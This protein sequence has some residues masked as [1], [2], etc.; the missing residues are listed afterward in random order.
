MLII[1]LPAKTAAVFFVDNSAKIA[2]I[3]NI[4]Q[5]DDILDR[6]S[7]ANATNST[8]KENDPENASIEKLKFEVGQ[9]MGIKPKAKNKKN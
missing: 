6:K 1:I 5:G 7:D 3:I 8:N 9:E 4:G 2:R